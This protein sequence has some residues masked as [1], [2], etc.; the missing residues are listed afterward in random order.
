MALSMFQASVPVITQ[1]LNGLAGVVDKGK[2]QA[3]LSNELAKWASG[4]FAEQD[5]L[6]EQTRDLIR[7]NQA[8]P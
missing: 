6:I 3:I 8:K 2:Q 7:K 5:K 4:K 1:L